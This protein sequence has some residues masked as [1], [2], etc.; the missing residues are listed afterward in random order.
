VVVQFVIISIVSLFIIF[1][2]QFNLLTTCSSEAVSHCMFVVPGTNIGGGAGF[3]LPCSV[4]P[5]VSACRRASNFI[6]DRYLRW[7]VVVCF[8]R[9]ILFHCLHFR[10]SGACS[11]LAS[12]TDSCQDNR[13]SLSSLLVLS[14]VSE[15]STVG[16][17]C[18]SVTVL[19]P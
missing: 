15:K 11:F 18:L 13:S 5:S 9:H 12:S 6:C 3:F 8:L 16:V 10:G 7:G 17:V 14:S 19:C 4:L 2:V 1:E